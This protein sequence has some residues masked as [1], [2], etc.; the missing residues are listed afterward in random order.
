MLLAAIR[1]TVKA[2]KVMA[3]DFEWDTEKNSDGKL[4]RSFQSGS[5]PN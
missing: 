4:I 3:L 1:E 2:Q 5:F